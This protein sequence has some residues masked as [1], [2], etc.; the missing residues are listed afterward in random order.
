MPRKTQGPHRLDSSKVKQLYSK[1]KNVRQV[2][3][4]L[5]ASYMGV[6]RNLLVQGVKLIPVRAAAGTAG[7]AAAQAR[8]KP[9]G[10]GRLSREDIAAVARGVASAVMGSATVQIQPKTREELWES[11]EQGV[12][13]GFKQIGFRP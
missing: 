11:I 8:A 7:A 1:L 6:R 3:I 4:E 10:G 9:A 12:E 2:A 5:G 13:S